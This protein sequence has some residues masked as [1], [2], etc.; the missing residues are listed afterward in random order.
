MLVLNLLTSQKSAFLPCR[1]DS[2]HRFTQ[3]LAW[4]RDTLVRLVV[5]YFTSVGEGGGNAAPKVE[6]FHF[7]VKI[8]PARANPLTDFYNF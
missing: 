4:F 3:D 6:N 7:L 8:R 5:R 2:L 1:G